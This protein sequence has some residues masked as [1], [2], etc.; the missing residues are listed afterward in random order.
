MHGAVRASFSSEPDASHQKLLFR[1]SRAEKRSFGVESC[2]HTL[3]SAD[4][5]SSLQ[6]LMEMARPPL[7]RF[8]NMP[9]GRE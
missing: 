5:W 7:V 4:F 3:A 6:P 2:T 1:D 9:E 8:A